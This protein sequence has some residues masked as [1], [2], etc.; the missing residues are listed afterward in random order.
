MKKRYAIYDH[1]ND[2][3]TMRHYD[4]SISFANSILDGDMFETKK[5]VMN[6]V[7]KIK[8]TMCT[9]TTLEIKKVYE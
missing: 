9:T 6:E 8:K 3:Y 2:G 4:N 1:V 7:K 5:E